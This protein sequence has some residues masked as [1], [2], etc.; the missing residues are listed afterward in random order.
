MADDGL[1]RGAA[2]A[3]YAMFSIVP[4]L[5]I[6]VDI[7]SILYGADATRGAVFGQIRAVIGPDNASALQ[8]L[9]VASHR[10]PAGLVARI[11][12]LGMLLITASGVFGELQTALNIIWRRDRPGAR[13][14]GKPT[15]TA[16][17]AETLSVM[18]LLRQRVLV[19]GLLV[20]LALLLLVSLTLNAALSTLL[21][22]VNLDFPGMFRMLQAL[23]LLLSFGLVVL[24]CAA[25][26]RI[27]PDHELAWRDIWTGAAITS[28]LFMIGET[29]IG[30]YI[31]TMV[32]ATSYGAAGALIVVMLWVYYSAQIF[33][34]G[35]EFTRTIAARR[36]APRTRAGPPT[37]PS[38]R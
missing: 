18:H 12:T 2:V 37:A 5:A 27:L 31:G 3:F 15:D 32:P 34:L 7:V 11:A 6:V 20:A 4:V 25:T 28:V 23:N 19:L 22:Q 38:L 26:Y 10:R 35:A 16:P 8:D 33:L 36:E 29:L 24:L 17:P 13:D 21:G 1:S 14:T 9:L 30:L